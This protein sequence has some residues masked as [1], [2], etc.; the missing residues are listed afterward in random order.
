MAKKRNYTRQPKIDYKKNLTIG[1]LLCL[2]TATY[3][4]TLTAVSS[5]GGVGAIVS[6]VTGIFSATLTADDLVAGDSADTNPTIVI[7]KS[8]AGAGQ[9][10]FQDAT[11]Q[12]AQITLDSNEALLIRTDSNQAMTFGTN[13]SSNMVLDTSGQLNLG[14][15]IT[16]GSAYVN[17]SSHNAMVGIYGSTNTGT[18]H[19]SMG[20]NSPTTSTFPWT[21]AKVAI[22]SSN[23]TNCQTS[24]IP[25]F[26]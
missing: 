2:I 11:A 12:R 20:D 18:T 24:Y 26:K 7:N 6:A 13:S 4:Y 15:T 10:V 25:A 16:N 23:G 17:I 1:F 21:W 14:S 3:G 5:D 22:C 19:M 9:V 8:N